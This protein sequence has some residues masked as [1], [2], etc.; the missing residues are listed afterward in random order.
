ML[1]RIAIIFLFLISA[2]LTF[3]D[4]RVYGS[5]T[6]GNVGENVKVTFKV[7]GFQDVTG[8]QFV[9]KYDPAKLSFVKF[10]DLSALSL[11]ESTNFSVIANEGKI[12]TQ[13]DDPQTTGADLANGTILL[14]VVFNGICGDQSVVNLIKDGFFDLLFIDPFGDVIPSTIEAAN[15]TITGAP[16][17]GEK[18]VLTVNSNIPVKSGE[19]ICIPIKAGTG[20]ESISGMKTDIVFPDGCGTINE[21]RNLTTILPGF[22]VNDIAITGNKVLLNWS[23][24]GA[25]TIAAGTTI[26]EI[27]Y[28][29]GDGCCDQTKPI[30]FQNS[31]FTK[32]GGGTLDVTTDGSM[33]VSCDI[34]QP[35][36][37]TGFGLIASDHTAPTG[38]NIKMTVSVKDFKDIVS[39][40]YSLDWDPNCLELDATTPVELPANNLLTGL[41]LGSFNSPSQGCLIVFWFD[42]E[43]NGFTLPDD[44]VLF[45]VNF[46]VKGTSGI[47]KV[48]F[49]SKCMSSTAEILDVNG[50]SLP[51]NFC[52]G[53]VTIGTAVLGI[54]DVS[55]KDATCADACNGSVEVSVVGATNPV[56]SW[57]NGAGNVTKLT[58]LCPGNYTVTVTDGANSTSKT[59]TISAPPAIVVAV[60]SVTPATGGGNNGAID[61]NVSGGSGNFSYQWSTT[62]PSTTQDISNLAAGNYTVTVT[63]VNNSCTSTLAVTV[64]D[65]NTALSVSINAKKY[66]ELDLSCSGTCD[67]EL[68]AVPAGGKPPY[69]YKWSRDGVTTS[70]LSNVCAG[71]YTVT[72]TDADGKTS[73]A[74][75]AIL[76]PSPIKADFDITYP[77]DAETK[78]GSIRVIPSGGAGGYTYQWTN[79]DGVGNVDAVSGIGVGVYAVKV[80]DKNGC[81]IV[82]SKT[83]TPGGKECF[84]GIGA[85]TPNG[86]GKNDKLLI[87]CLGNIQNKLIIFNRWG[88]KVYES[89]NYSNNWEGTD[90]TG[91]PLPDGGYYWVLEVKETTGAIQVY[92]G[93]VSIIRSF[94]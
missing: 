84:E 37:F 66:G 73:T 28:T 15:V 31:T 69:A 88:Q 48:N 71:S 27:C 20:F 75:Y 40:G 92:K 4:I 46:K 24:S 35:C 11:S 51:L 7:D 56:I 30:A 47:C 32:S 61:I 45:T 52:S 81:S 19:Q 16:C 23:S 77:T 68:T 59:Y 76:S 57:S 5:A 6:P 74:N 17:G 41:T 43:A 82:F 89:S 25:G 8:F 21:I 90:G 42:S 39:M 26:F 9:I 54:V 64:T 93:A 87:T 91:N 70:V 62:P 34:V 80:T 63:D 12:K 79:P 94:K 83:L 3:A 36:N 78:D 18:P 13:W 14:S 49:G 86:D 65:G 72:I 53:D 85:I 67:G 10:D 55:K 22:D 2:S 1:Q 38:S 44:Y 29:P 60:A 33:K 58:N 50:T